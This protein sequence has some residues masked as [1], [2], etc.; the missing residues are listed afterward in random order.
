MEIVRFREVR[1]LVRSGDSPVI[2]IA[3]PL[4]GDS[5]EEEL[6]NEIQKPLVNGYDLGLS[7]NSVLGMTRPAQSPHAPTEILPSQ[8][9]FAN[10]IVLANIQ[11]KNSIE[12]V[13]FNPDIISQVI[14]DVQ[15][16]LKSDPY[17]GNIYEPE[18]KHESPNNHIVNDIPDNTGLDMPINAEKPDLTFP[19]V[20][21]AVPPASSESAEQISPSLF[22]HSIDGTLNAEPQSFDP[23]ASNTPNNYCL[24]E[25]HISAPETDKYTLDQFYLMRC[26]TPISSIQLTIF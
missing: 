12:D 26:L 25:N 3:V 11:D 14:P 24:Q 10:N 18:A 19:S 1:L 2:F 20:A 6:W 8:P 9:D 15:H 5:I 7:M 17:Q 4:N 23:P 21:D 13:T 22:D 16:H